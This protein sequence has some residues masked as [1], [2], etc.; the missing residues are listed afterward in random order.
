MQPQGG[1]GWVL[2]SQQDDK[3]E[4]AKAKSQGQEGGVGEIFLQVWEG[5]TIFVSVLRWF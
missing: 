5:K 1:P 3:A 4:E 2:C